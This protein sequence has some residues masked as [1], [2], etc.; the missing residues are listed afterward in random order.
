M[1]VAAG[2]NGRFL[3]GELMGRPE[4][5][6]A[7]R[8]NM[9]LAYL[10][11]RGAASIQEL[12][13]ALGA[14][15]S[16]M[17][18]DLEQLEEVGHLRRTHGGAVLSSSTHST[19]EPETAVAAQVSR[20]EKNAIG[21]AAAQQLSAGDSV[22]FDS[23]TTVL[24]A[25]RFV[26]ERRLA[27]TAVTNDLGIGQ[28][29]AGSDNV[30]VVVLGG[31]VRRGSLTL[32]GEPGQSFIAD[33]HADVAF[34]GTHSIAAGTLSDTSIEIASI[35][36]AMISA[37]R[38]VILL[39]DSSKFQ[40]AAFYKIC[41]IADVHEVITDSGATEQHL[42]QLHELGLKVRVVETAGGVGE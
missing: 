13:D 6:P 18:R 1:R 20:A 31:S 40:P 28:V 16:T 32:I 29:L 26:A 7:Q 42:A 36:R 34:I 9:V 8:R 41:D 5:I 30:R 14:S 15:P 37:A 12:A 38:R 22:I 23:G 11:Q 3:E 24:A 4:V 27:L 10:L 33:I 25:A 21:R 19:F 39:A 35:K 2:P 17:R